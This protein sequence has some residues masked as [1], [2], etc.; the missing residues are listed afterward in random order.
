MKTVLITGANKGIGFETAKQLA[1]LGYFVY[2][3]CRDQSKGE[4]AVNKLNATGLSNVAFLQ[5]DVRDLDSVV[6]ARA[7]LES[8]IESLDI[9]INNAGIAGSG[10]Q[11]LSTVDMQSLRDLFDINFF[12]AVQTTQQ[13]LSLLRKAKHPV[14]VNVSSELGSLSLNSSPERRPNW[15]LYRAYGASKVALNAFTILLGNELS[16]AGFKVNSVTPGYTATDLN[17]YQGTK[18]VAAGAAPIVKLATIAE[19]GVSG[20]FFSDMG[21]IS[22]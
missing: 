16:G 12:G 15:E 20:K 1:E 18:T 3:G 21:E 9:L 19:D 8:T 6:K 22:W 17:Q 7:R 4:D 10:S 11:D 2:L 14:I 13:F 5:I